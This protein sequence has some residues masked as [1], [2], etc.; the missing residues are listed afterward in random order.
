MVTGCRKECRRTSPR[1]SGWRRSPWDRVIAG[2]GAEGV[3]RTG[4]AVLRE[5][6]DRE[7]AHW[8]WEA[9]LPHEDLVDRRLAENRTR[10]RGAQRDRGGDAAADDA[11]AAASHRLAAWVMP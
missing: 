10:P 7:A 11:A 1:P 6:I 3:H 4:P 9:I 8:H 2:A 5:R